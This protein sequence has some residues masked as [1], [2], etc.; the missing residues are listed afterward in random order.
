MIEPLDE[1]F[2]G[3]VNRL[4]RDNWAGPMIVSAGKAHDTSN[5]DGFIS[6][7]NDELTG[8]ALYEIDNGR[9]ELL[10]LESMTE[11]RGVGSTLVNAVIAQARAQSCAQVWLVTTN[12]NIRAIRFYQRYGFVLGCVRV[13]ALE[14]ARLLKP[15]I[16]TVGC[17]GIPI[18]DEL[19]FVYPL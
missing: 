19:E 1:R 10:V 9:C 12:D 18:R 11:N 16:P 17:E 13:N 2:R 5:A 14:S 6:I 4:V 8:Y 7:E 15:A 3:A